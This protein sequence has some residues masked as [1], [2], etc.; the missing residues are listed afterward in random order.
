MPRSLLVLFCALLTFAGAQLRAQE[1]DPL[2]APHAERYNADL[3]ALRKTRKAETTRYETE[4]AQKLDAVIAAA[5]DEAT[6]TKLRKEREGVVKGMLVPANPVGLPEDAMAAR[7]V[8][9]NGAGKASFEFNAAKKKLDE[10]YLKT[11]AGLA[12]QARGKTA[13]KGLAAQV[14]EEKRRVTAGN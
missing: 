10:A 2:L 13:P 9:L 4:Y 12:K 1:L 5:K 14:A 7:K 3:E 6:I 11:L 8:F